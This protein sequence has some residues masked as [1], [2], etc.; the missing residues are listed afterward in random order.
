M[1]Y[2]VSDFGAIHAPV[3]GDTNKALIFGNIPVLKPAA[4]L[5]PELTAFLGRWE[6]YDTSGPVK[7]DTKIVIVI[8]FTVLAGHDHDTWTDTY[9]D[10]A[11]YQWLLQYHRP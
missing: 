3:A 6:G 11:F 7:N 5:A 2:L 1:P 9:S 10:P 4:D 8:Q